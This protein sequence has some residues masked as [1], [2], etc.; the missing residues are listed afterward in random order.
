VQDF[1][2][3]TV[4]EEIVPFALINQQEQTRIVSE[5]ATACHIAVTDVEDVYPTSAL[6]E[7]MMA[8]GLRKEGAYIAQKV[9]RI[10][11][12]FDMP[13]FQEAWAAVID[14]EAILRTRIVS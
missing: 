12:D 4:T 9:F 13:R 8:L 14:K 5:A 2:R 10:P 7:G 3:D 1:Q 11:Q 6:Q